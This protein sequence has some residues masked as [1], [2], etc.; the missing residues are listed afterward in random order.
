MS[1][2]NNAK[3]AWTHTT[4]TRVFTMDAVNG[5]RSSLTETTE[6]FEV[7]EE[8]G[9]DPMEVRDASDIRCFRRDALAYWDSA[10]EGRGRK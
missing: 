10:W 8:L 1:K 5:L 3:V 6:V 2:K 9:F 7:A 4:T